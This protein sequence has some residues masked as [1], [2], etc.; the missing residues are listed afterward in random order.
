MKWL[1]G[2]ISAQLW[3]DRDYKLSLTY[4]N[5]SGLYGYIPS[6]EPQPYAECIGERDSL[7]INFIDRVWSVSSINTKLL[8]LSTVSL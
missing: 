4:Y 7:V 3:S 8:R 2:Y 1:S 6:N 5:Y